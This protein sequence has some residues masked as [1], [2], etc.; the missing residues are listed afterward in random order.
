MPPAFRARL[1]GPPPEA[2]DPGPLLEELVGTGLVNRTAGPDAARER[3]IRSPDPIRYEF[4]ELVRECMAARVKRH[5]QDTG[6]RGRAAVWMAYGERYG[7]LSRQFRATEQPGALEAAAELGRRGLVYL[8]RAGAEDSAGDPTNDQDAYDKLTE[9]A[10]ELV[11]GTRDPVLLQGV[12]VELTGLAEGLAPGKTRWKIRAILA[13]AL[14]QSGQPDRA[15][16]LYQQAGEEAEAAR[17]WVDAAWIRGNWAGALVNTGKP[18]AAEECYLKSAKAL[19]KAGR[20]ETEVIQ[21][22]LDRLR[23]ILYG[24]KIETALPE[25]EKRLKRLRDWWRRAGQPNE[26]IFSLTFCKP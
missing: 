5:P 20:P 17:Y 10:T 25:I 11:T 22:E 14:W 15:L 18:V 2:P 21:V 1:E 4:H 13:D 7:E 24:G 16:A 3:D 9:F 12:V 6:G 8:V 26:G 19:K 23:V